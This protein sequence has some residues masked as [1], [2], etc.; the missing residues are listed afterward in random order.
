MALLS[1][2]VHSFCFALSETITRANWREV[3]AGASAF[4][5]VFLIRIVVG[6]NASIEPRPC[7]RCL[8]LHLRLGLYSIIVCS[9]R[10]R[11]RLAWPPP[12]PSPTWAVVQHPRNLCRFFQRQGRRLWP[13]FHPS[14]PPSTPGCPDPAGFLG[15]W[16]VLPLPCQCSCRCQGRHLSLLGWRWRARPNRTFHCPGSH[17]RPS[18]GPR[19]PPPRSGH[20]ASGKTIVGCFAVARLE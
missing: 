18:A 14:G 1:R 5:R 19:P 13:C 2:L 16:S 11:R 10:R 9:R 8:R 6:L 20:E 4:T 15:R 3:G 17:N 12:L 7:R